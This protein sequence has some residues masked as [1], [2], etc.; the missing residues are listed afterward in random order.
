MFMAVFTPKTKA[1]FEKFAYL[2]GL[3]KL[4]IVVAGGSCDL[5][6]ESYRLA[7]SSQ[8]CLLFCHQSARI[9][10]SSTN[11]ASSL[12]VIFASSSVGALS[13]PQIILSAPRRGRIVGGSAVW[14]GAPHL[15][16]PPSFFLPSLF[17]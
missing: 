12:L 1:E 17:S 11:A 13:R 15:S 10:P 2:F 6:K 8:S 7:A 9:L 3:P 4:H 14:A 16:P 5:S